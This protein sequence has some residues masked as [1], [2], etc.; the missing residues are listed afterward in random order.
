MKRTLTLLFAA[1][2]AI[3]SVTATASG[4][5]TRAN[6]PASATESP[7]S[8]T[9]SQSKLMT[10]YEKAETAWRKAE[11]ADRPK[12]ALAA[13]E[14]MKECAAK[15]DDAWYYYEACREYR[16]VRIR[17]SWKEMEEADRL[18]RSEIESCG[19]PVALFHYKRDYQGS[20]DLAFFVKANA[21]ELAA[22]HNPRFY[23]NLCGE[24]VHDLVR[25]RLGND[26]EYC[27]WALNDYGTLKD[28]YKN[29]YPLGAIAEYCAIGLSGSDARESLLKAYAEKYDGREVESLARFDLLRLAFGKLEQD[30]SGA[31]ETDFKTIRKD[32]DALRAVV[33]KAP[34][35]YDFEFLL[36]GIDAL[37]ASLDAKTVD[38]S[39][40]DGTVTLL[41][42]NLAGC[43]VKL[44]KD[45]KI[46]WKK[47]VSTDVSH[48]YVRDTVKFALGAVDDGE[49]EFICCNLS[50]KEE[51]YS[52]PYNQFTVSLALK[53]DA[54]GQAVYAAD[55]KSGKP[56]GA[57]TLRLEDQNGKE[58][59]RMAC[60]TM[61]KGFVY[62]DKE[63]CSHLS[64]R[65]SSY[66]KA[67]YR[68]ADGHL[69]LSDAKYIRVASQ[70]PVYEEIQ[71]PRALLLSDRGAYKP[72]EKLCFKAIFYSGTYE[73]ATVPAGRSVK[74]TLSDA[75]GKEMASSLL[76]TNEFGSVAGEFRLPEGG[77]GGMWR[78]KAESGG[79]QLA[80][81]YVRVDEF[82]L[83]TFEVE[84]DE[85][86]R[87][88]M[89]GDT[90]RI[91]GRIASYSGHP[92]SEA[93]VSY[94]VEGGPEIKSGSIAPE[95][96]GRFSI[97]FK[98]SDNRWASHQITLK[99]K[100]G[101]GETLEFYRYVGVTGYLSVGLELTNAAEGDCDFVSGE[102][103]TGILSSDI[104]Q[105][106]IRC[107]SYPTL[108]MRYTLSG[109]SGL[110]ESAGC[111]PG[112]LTL[113]MTGKPSGIYCFYL[114]SELVAADGKR[115]S[116]ESDLRILRISD[117]A[118]A[119]PEGV[120]AFFK[121]IE[122]GSLSVQAGSSTG[123]TWI[124]AELY[125]E[126]N[127]LLDHR[128]CYL[129]GNADKA[130][131]L[132]GIAFER[133]ASYP[134]DLSIKLFFF[135][136]GRAFSYS[137]NF[138]AP[139]SAER[140]PLQFTR[141]SDTA[142]PGGKYT[143]K[144]QTRAGA[145]C[146]A[147]IYD[148]SS[149]A[150]CA[151][152][153]YEVEPAR[154][155]V[156][157][158]S[159]DWV[160]GSCALMY[161]LFEDYGSP[162]LLTKSYARVMSA[163]A[164]V[165]EAAILT[166]EYAMADGAAPDAEEVRV[167]SDFATTICWQ[168]QLHSSPDGSVS[169]DFT[170][171][172][173]LSTY[174][175]Q[176]F[177]HDKKFDN[178]VLKR[179]MLVTIPVKVAIVEPQFLYEGDSYAVNVTLSSNLPAE[180]EG[181]LSLAFFDGS[182]IPAGTVPAASKALWRQT[183][184]MNV[185]SNGSIRAGFDAVKVS[186]VEELAILVRFDSDADS[187][188]SDA[189]LVRV[190]CKPAY[191]T[192]TEAHS[193]LLHSGADKAALEAQ[194]RS[195]FVNIPG[196]QAS[197]REISI[198]D[199]LAAALPENI[200]NVS[201]NAVSL[202]GAIYAIALTDSLRRSGAFGAEAAAGADTGDFV[203]RLKACLNE[204]GGFAWMAGMYSSPL[205]T[206]LVLE[207]AAS[208][209]LLRQE[210]GDKQLAAAVK[211]LDKSY[212]S[213]KKSGYYG[214][215]GFEAYLHVRSRYA[216]VEFSTKGAD[217]ALLRS[218]RKEVKA[219]LVPSGERGL[220]AQLI[221]KARRIEIL[222]WLNGSEE[223]RTLAR[224]FGIRC[225]AARRMAKSS[226]ADVISLSQYAVAHDCGGYYFPNAVMPFRGLL[227]S[228]LYAHTLICN[229]LGCVPQHSGI[230]EG[231]RLW[232]MI[233]KETQ[234]W[235]SDP[236]FIEALACVACAGKETLDTRVLVLEAAAD[237]P[238]GSVS[239]SGNGMSVRRMY[240]RNGKPLR[241]GTPVCV[242]DKIRAEYR[243][244]SDENRSFVRLD[245]ARPASLRPSDQLSG[246]YGVRPAVDGGFL[247]F[248]PQVYREVRSERS[249]YW[250]D[251]CP[252]EDII[253]SEEF[254]VSQEGSFQS[255]ALE[256]ESL[257]ASHYRAVDDDPAEFVSVQNNENDMSLETGT[258]KGE[259][260]EAG[261]FRF[262][263]GPRTM[264]II[265]GMSLTDVSA[266][267]AVVARQYAVCSDDFTIYV[268]DRRKALPEGFTIA[269][270]AED[271]VAM[272]QSE[273]L[274][275]VCLMGVSQGGMMAQYIA[276]K[277]P[278]LVERLL[279][280][281]TL[282][283]STPV[284]RASFEVWRA[285]ALKGDSQALSHEVNTRVFSPE[286]YSKHEKAFALLEKQA[287]PAGRMEFFLRS[288]E[289]SAGF[290]ALEDL[291]DIKCPVRVIGVEDDTVLGGEA[292][293]E[294]A[295]TLGCELEM[296][297]G[298][299]HAIYDEDAAFPAKVREFFLDR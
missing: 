143:F 82:V 214:G 91:T 187:Q 160:T 10:A 89:P 208:C 145:E 245:A 123:P 121:N 191:R 273:D 293:R 133:K 117:D 110:K 148:A 51:Y 154:R 236:A 93:V 267:A 167:R 149:A 90:A 75:E 56:L 102:Y 166:D 223:G 284:C 186:A 29:A 35:D 120:Q 144:V 22:Q 97:E 156:G 225:C 138:V 57:L 170:A 7:A 33:R 269:D 119:L 248:R 118:T 59:A 115:Y 163:N 261:W 299:G 5:E 253:L 73:Y 9:A 178:A 109:P 266:S 53:S 219:Y 146:A 221:S 20:A 124:V 232:M 263:S 298:K 238:F 27:L 21:R 218:F 172:D 282:A 287:L 229:V 64:D 72:G 55:Y 220:K 197:A 112:K 94:S 114:E 71:Q 296:Y 30:G 107:N 111:A 212:F 234:Q 137:R 84:W 277:H 206:A 132:A 251:V 131:S 285:A 24:G 86:D 100:D 252:E 161:S 196:A 272:M 127:R 192:I 98:C 104:A 63:F 265:P 25:P 275:G 17:T 176:I 128:V 181:S 58:L 179:E 80:M 224:D 40:E 203:K 42:R 281:S 227:E 34:S 99:V 175:V 207:R 286:F 200:S 249:I 241:E 74:L 240:Y 235:E 23:S 28:Y 106:D 155:P 36:D 244:H 157:Y 279:L 6:A 257:Y 48:Y 2:L 37:S 62:L 44:E 130:G 242:G 129:E 105:I 50:G 38:A 182:Q 69:R 83:P 271:A 26:Y 32:L 61:A 60:A 153:W 231:V 195:S 255:P 246:Y 126:G 151:N 77:R 108:K 65:R 226:D 268:I 276:E 222:R 292:S 150:I 290:S 31:K 103:G 140:L 169:F 297:P 217:N 52:S 101:T 215:P 283:H 113:D 95:A 288:S 3:G 250:M 185:P 258:F 66:I 202:S 142:V 76:T 81:R 11:Q 204:D 78:L 134:G 213:K 216:G 230:A 162:R 295:A 41:L 199:M 278:E 260:F 205:V 67:E 184:H 243:I 168:P 237:K 96:D 233:Q 188:A 228:E 43:L 198:L 280:V 274:R 211:Y 210:I 70:E 85:S 4:A 16:N 147:S 158:V 165:E 18:F 259:G 209:P 189:V 116:E 174:Y 159:Y 136:N 19:A 1:L 183:K 47:S 122:D 239:A 262:G 291:K 54:A 139:Q 294:I 92:L 45:G 49:Y 289:A 171:S 88:L 164:A 15:L 256:I 13:L 247:R 194:L 254:L 264:V 190:P 201:D 180:A 68:D 152:D 173:K 8:A 270:M 39:F 14:E 79:R 125:G 12:D 87:M 135:K 141:F 46:V 177:A 193:A